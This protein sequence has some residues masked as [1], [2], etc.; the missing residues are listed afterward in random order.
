MKPQGEVATGH[1]IK[2]WCGREW[3]FTSTTSIDRYAEPQEELVSEIEKEH[4]SVYGIMSKLCK[5]P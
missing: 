4:K 2:K 5:E 3:I 1:K